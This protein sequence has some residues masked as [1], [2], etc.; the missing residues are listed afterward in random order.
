M[1]PSQG[2]STSSFG[3]NSISLPNQQPEGQS[4]A[5]S[6]VPEVSFRLELDGR[7]TGNRTLISPSGSS[8]GTGQLAGTMQKCL[9]FPRIVTDRPTTWSISPG[10][11][12]TYLDACYPQSFLSEKS[13]D[14]D[15]LS[16]AGHAGLLRSMSA[17]TVDLERRAEPDNSLN[18][19]DSSSRYLSPAGDHIDPLAGRSTSCPSMAYVDI[20]YKSEGLPPGTSSDVRRMLFRSNDQEED[21]IDLAGEEIDDLPIEPNTVFPELPPDLLTDNC[22]TTIGNLSL[23]G[24]QIS[25]E[26]QDTTE[27][28][29][30]SQTDEKNKPS[31]SNDS[32]KLSNTGDDYVNVRDLPKSTISDAMKRRQP[33]FDSNS[34]NVDTNQKCLRW[35]NALPVPRS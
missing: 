18:S 32:K 33:A 21:D 14:P 1:E 11:S 17:R 12:R 19:S 15:R 27:E 16:I 30:M 4:D 13:V 26:K 29:R 7:Q 35:L 6:R 5:M 9:S 31:I 25:N 23:K 3:D 2:K 24:L 22:K 20:P 8:S 34:Q 10:Q 28:S